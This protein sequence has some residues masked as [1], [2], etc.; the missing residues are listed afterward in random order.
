VRT[1]ITI[2][3]DV[4]R[5]AKARAART[6]QTVSQVIEDA[7]REA[8]RP[9][10]AH[11]RDVEELPTFGGSGVL[12]GVDLANRSALLDAMDGESSVDALR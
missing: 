9:K 2:S 8:L 11:P 5:D 10:P 1:T 12:P 7:V 4:Y 6:S 3:E